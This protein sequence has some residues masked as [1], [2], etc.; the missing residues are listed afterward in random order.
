MNGNPIQ[1]LHAYQLSVGASGSWEITHD[2]RVGLGL[3]YISSNL[4][5]GP[6]SVGTTGIH[7][8]H[9]FAVD[10]GILYQKSFE[11]EYVSLKP[12]AGWSLTNFGSPL[13]YSSTNSDPLPMTMRGGVGR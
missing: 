10:L 8:A 13:Q 5:P 9:A 12:S 7:D 2:L 1:Q 6:V 4:A 11:T 3:R